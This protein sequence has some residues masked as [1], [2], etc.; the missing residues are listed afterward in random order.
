MDKSDKIMFFGGLLLLVIIL[1]GGYLILANLEHKPLT[2][3]LMEERNDKI[4]E[5]ENSGDL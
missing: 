3:N 4:M 1:G 2:T 5:L